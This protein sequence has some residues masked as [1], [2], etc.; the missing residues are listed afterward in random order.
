MNLIEQIKE[1][2]LYLDGGMGSLIQKRVSHTGPVPEVLN[3][4]HPEIIG[5]IQREYVEAG[6]NILV[7]NTFGANGYKAAGCG[8]TVDELV[9]AAVAIARAQNPDYVA[10]DIGP[11]GA[12]IGDLGDISFARA[13]AYF[14]EMVK[15]GVK[16]GAD[17]ILIETMTDIYE[18]RAAV[19]AAKENSDLPVIASM[20]Y[21]ETGRTLTGSDPLTVVTILEA[22]GVDA[23]GINCST[24]PEQMLPIIDDLV[25]YASVP[26]A[27]E[28]NAGL[29]RVVDGETQYDIGPEQFAGYMRQIA[30]KGACI[31]GGCCGT[32]PEHIALTIE[33]TRDVPV[34]V[35]EATPD[36]TATRIATATRT[37]TL[38]QDIRVIGEGINPSANKALKED[39]R[40]GS[41]AMVKQLA[42][43]QKKLGADI[44]DVNVG[45]PEIDEKETM[46]RAVKEISQLVDL[47]LQIDSTKPEVIEAVL[48]EYN[49]KVLVNSVN[50]EEKSMA[51][52]LPPVRRYGACVLGLTLD[53]D[54]IPKTR[55]KRVEIAEKIINR[56]K[57]EG[58]PRKNILIDCLVLTASAQ[59]AGVVQTLGAVSDVKAKFGVPTVLGV[60]NISFGLPERRLVNRTFLVMAMAAGLDTPII[61]AGDPAMMDAISAYRALAGLDVGCRDYVAAHGKSNS[62]D[63]IQTKST[64][65]AES[66]GI[67]DLK[68]MV[69][70]GLKDDIVPAVKKAL[71]EM[72]PMEIVNRYLIPGLDQVGE[73]FEKGDIF[74][75]NL[76]FSGETVQN[77]FAEIKKAMG[78]GEQASE[79]TIILATVKGDVHDI[80][81]N[82][83]KVIMENYGYRI[84]DMGKDVAGE[85]ILEKA[86]SEDVKLVGLSALMTTTVKNMESTIALFRKELPD[87]KIMV[88]GA[89]MNEEY[90]ASIG[91][92]YYGKDARAGVEIARKVFGSH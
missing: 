77:A 24:G 3:L 78:N 87:V 21:E 9:S 40:T 70:D 90:A 16:A 73:D 25:R 52:I 10:L 41:M 37:L 75:P 55:E 67:P 64:Q 44:L 71:E 27:V 12:L 36:N 62:R 6:A 17:L 74:L 89:V 58:I 7:S 28:P 50:G 42:L 51:A 35:I 26:I 57:D 32:T 18:A 46:L 30:E 34:K 86:R 72:E 53:E 11:I 38:G 43:E 81:K 47:P 31:L 61:K 29:P 14:A 79:G 92:D 33:A 59:Q 15:S 63:E 76:I 69:V 84:I 82:I 60:S 80:G 65:Q 85:A 66:S 88:G 54:G 8:H 23:I 5:A 49:G 20:T 2:R 39:L 56:A 68:A 48:A 1:K 83:L 13:K 4:T 22:L 19:L 91:A 45:L